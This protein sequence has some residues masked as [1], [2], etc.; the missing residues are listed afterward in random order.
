MLDTFRLT[1]DI[2]TIVTM[3]MP[4]IDEVRFHLLMEEVLANYEVKRKTVIDLENDIPEK[5]E[6]FTAAKRLEGLSELTLTNYN[7]IL[8]NFASMFNK[9]AVHVTTPDI[10]LYLGKNTGLKKSTI[11]S[12]LTVLKSFFG[13][14]QKEEIML[15]DPTAKI[16][17]PKKEQRLLKGLTIEELEIVREAC[18]TVRQ[19]ALIEFLYS[20]GLRLSEVSQLN[21]D[22]LNLQDLSVTVIGKGNKERIVYSNFKA[23]HHLRKYLKS[24]NDGCPALFATERTYENGV[25]RLSNRGIQYEIDKI[26]KNSNISKKLT[27][28]VFRHTFATLSM[29]QGIE[30]ADLQ[31][32]LGHSN[33]A[34]TLIYGNVSEERK[35]SA[36]KR[37]HVH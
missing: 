9:A 27:P 16:P 2:N 24:R 29:D 26:E 22:S 33:P 31:H 23:M 7:Y 18:E 10:R 17:T 11:S 28:H 32:L 8:M 5:I 6:M 1:S 30:L 34:T 4:D 35:K 25:R 20:T 3:L 37:Y 21:R 13:W 19:R 14:M 12:K 36:Y 15:R